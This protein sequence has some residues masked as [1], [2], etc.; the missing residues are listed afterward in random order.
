MIDKELLRQMHYH[1]TQNLSKRTSGDINRI[2][3]EC[4][5]SIRQ[6]TELNNEVSAAI[7]KGKYEQL[8]MLTLPIVIYFF[9]N[10]TNPG[11]FTPL[12]HNAFGILISTFLITLYLFAVWLSKKI[13]DIEV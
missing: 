4:S 12:Y 2:I 1:I 7:A 9:I 8:I 5:N 10:I 13:L 6:K 11:F 3:R